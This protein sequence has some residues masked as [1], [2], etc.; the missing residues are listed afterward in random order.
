MFSFLR[1]SVR[2]GRAY[3]KYAVRKR[4]VR[5]RVDVCAGA[6]RA[7]GKL[8]RSSATYVLNTFAKGLLRKDH[9]NDQLTER[10]FVRRRARA[11]GDFEFI[12]VIF[13]RFPEIRIRHQRRRKM[14]GQKRKR[15]RLFKGKRN[16][17]ASSSRTRVY[18]FT[19][20]NC[21]NI[22]RSGNAEQICIYYQVNK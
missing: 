18:M 7:N 6:D 8:R 19:V 4:A 21:G 3:R 9:T 15:F 2:L 16:D 5:G 11:P 10:R 1:R 14:G 22:T 13:V 20:F 12:R 17:D